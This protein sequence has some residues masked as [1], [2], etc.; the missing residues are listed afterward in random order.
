MEDMVK[1]L[2]NKTQ[3]L[4][5]YLDTKRFSSEQIKAWI[6]QSKSEKDEDFDIIPDQ[7]YRQ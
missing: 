7:E 4:N 6:E 2:C 5:T 1:S 3:I